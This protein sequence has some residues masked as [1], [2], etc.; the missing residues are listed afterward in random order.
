MSLRNTSKVISIRLPTIYFNRL[1]FLAYH[2]GALPSEVAREA[3]MTYLDLGC[4]VCGGPIA[5]PEDIG[6]SNQA[7]CVNPDYTLSEGG[8]TL[9]PFADF[10]KSVTKHDLPGFYR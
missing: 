5:D 4:P 7:W 1:S 3:I 6:E 8:E 9:V 2:T 10:A